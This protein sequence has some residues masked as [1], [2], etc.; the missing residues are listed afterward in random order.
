M[1]RA[2]LTGILHGTGGGG[3]ICAGIMG[4]GDS[5]GEHDAV[6]VYKSV[7]Q[8]IG[9]KFHLGAGVHVSGLFQKPVQLAVLVDNHLSRRILIGTMHAGYLQSQRVVNRHMCTAAGALDWILRCRLVK[10][11]LG[12][13]TLFQ[14]FVVII[15]LEFDPLAL[16]LFLRLCADQVL[17]LFNGFCLGIIDVNNTVVQ[18]SV[19]TEMNVGIYKTGHHG[20]SACLNH[21]GLVTDIR[22]NLRIGTNRQNLSIPNGYRLGDIILLVHRQHASV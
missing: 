5:Q 7:Q 15:A 14:E 4:G 12:G 3:S 13:V 22:L 21:V 2:A 9:G 17:N 18:K 19:H 8:F 1:N 6:C 10:I 11:L 16:L 20:L